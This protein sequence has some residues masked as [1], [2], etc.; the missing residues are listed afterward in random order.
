MCDSHP[1]RLPALVAGARR[2]DDVVTQQSSQN[3]PHLHGRE[4]RADAAAN[5]AAVGDPFGGQR[6][7]GDQHIDIA[8]LLEQRERRAFLGEVRN[9]RRVPPPGR[10]LASFTNSSVL[11]ELRMSLAPRAASAVAIA[12]P[13][14]PVAPVRSAVLPPRSI[15]PGE[16]L[17]I[18]GSSI[19]AGN[20]C[21]HTRVVIG[22]GQRSV[23]QLQASHREATGG[24]VLFAR[25]A[26]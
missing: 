20:I 15:Y 1:T 7:V 11:R 10:D 8:G 14:P 4:G 13:S 26:D 3:K 25:D 19:S 18:D 22:L 16:R 24:E 9:M 2:A 17:S 21:E 6:C 5:P 12:R 23:A